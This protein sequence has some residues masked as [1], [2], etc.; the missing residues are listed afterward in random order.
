MGAAEFKAHCLQ[1][2]ERVRRTRQEVVITKRGVPVAKLV[3]ADPPRDRNLFG[4]LAAETTIV[5]DVMAPLYTDADWQAWEQE[6]EDQFLRGG[7]KPS[8]TRKRG[9]AGRVPK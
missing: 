7:W 9:R 6:R 5:G 1:V 4:C 2:M 8:T 3:P